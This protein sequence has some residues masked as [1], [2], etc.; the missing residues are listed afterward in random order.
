MDWDNSKVLEFECNYY[1]HR[2]IESFHITSNKDAMN[3]K[4][5]DLFPDIYRF[6]LQQSALYFLNLP[7]FCQPLG[8]SFCC[9]Y[10]LI[11]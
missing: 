6:M 10:C 9:F 1:T 11:F 3:E 2:F 7:S 4:R 5:S 8:S